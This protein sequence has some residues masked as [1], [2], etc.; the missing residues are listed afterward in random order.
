MI[1]LYCGDGKG[2]TTAA[3]GLAVRAAGHGKRVVFAQFMKGRISGELNVL[4]M[5]KNV[6][7]ARALE[8]EMFTFQ[9][10]AEQRKSAAAAN[11]MLLEFAERV[12]KAHDLDMVVLDEIVTA[13]SMGMV[14]EERVKRYISEFSRDKELVITGSTPEAWMIEMADYVTDMEK[15]KHPF[16]RGSEAREGVEY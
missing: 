2:K 15:I 6:T 1:H 10:N 4:S 5:L 14:S 11:A 8:N 9:M 3:V 7:V 12:A 16:D 13:V